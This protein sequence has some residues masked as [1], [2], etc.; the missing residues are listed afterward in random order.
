V[1][2]ANAHLPIV[3]TLL[4]MITFVKLVRWNA[5]SP[6]VVTLLGMVTLVNLVQ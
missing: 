4:G 2:T 3:V 1:Q 6:I 5:Y